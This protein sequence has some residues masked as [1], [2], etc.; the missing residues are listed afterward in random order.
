MQIANAADPVALL[1]QSLPGAVK[2]V[3]QFAGETTIVVDKARL[4]E[5]LKFLRDT[6]GLVFN[7]LSDISA[8][9]YFPDPATEQRPERFA[10]SYHLISLMYNRRLRVKVFVPEE[11]PTLPTSTTV[12]PAANWL[13]REIWDMM[14]IYFEGHPDPRRLLMPAD[15]DGHP[16]RRDTPLGYETIMFSFNQDEILKH[17]PSAAEGRTTE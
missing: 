7:F 3:K 17:K 2:Y 6:K 14:G 4:I 1:N 5:A 13:E 15:W 11:E 8:V 12:W 9:D 16:H 10:V